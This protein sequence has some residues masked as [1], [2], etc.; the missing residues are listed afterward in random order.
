MD[1]VR[2]MF[3]SSSLLLSLWMHGLRTAV[4]LL[5]KVLSK[6]VPKTLFKLWTGRKPNLRH[7]HVWG[8]PTV[9]DEIKV[10]VTLHTTSSKLD[11]HVVVEQFSNLYEQQMTNQIL[12]EKPIINE[13][14]EPTINVLIVEESQE[15]ILRRS[16][17]LIKTIVSNDYVVHL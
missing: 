2:S 11:I 8:Y 9:I 5:N 17:R 3:S 16:Q 10:Q 15:I 12:R 7:L 1:T 13:P 4:Y 6:A 14:I